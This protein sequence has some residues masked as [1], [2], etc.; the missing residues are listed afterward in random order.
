[1]TS[2]CWR[3][4]REAT[5]DRLDHAGAV[6]HEIMS[7]PDRGIQKKFW[8]TQVH[9]RGATSA[10]GRFIFG[11]ENGRAWPPAARKTAGARRP[12]LP[13]PAEAGI[14]DRR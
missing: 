11:A 7:A 6:L 3:N 1:M 5:V 10:Q 8:N 4:R 2:I 13:S 12:S 14:A 9:R